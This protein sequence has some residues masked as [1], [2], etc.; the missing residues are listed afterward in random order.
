MLAEVAVI[1]WRQSRCCS[2]HCL[3]CSNVVTPIFFT[4]HSRLVC[5]IGK[6]IALYIRVAKWACLVHARLASAVYI[7]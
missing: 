1:I 7:M 6:A 5:T 4:G 3:W 2:R